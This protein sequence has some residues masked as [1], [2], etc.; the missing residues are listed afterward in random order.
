M[1]VATVKVNQEIIAPVMSRPVLQ[2][3]NISELYSVSRSKALNIE[4]EN[5]S[6][7]L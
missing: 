1:V 7:F 4:E 5:M 3:P 6:G 2:D